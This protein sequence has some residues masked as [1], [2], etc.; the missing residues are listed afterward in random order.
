MGEE[1]PGGPWTF[2]RFIKAAIICAAMIGIL[3]V[4][5]SVFGV[6]IPAWAVTMFWIVLVAGVAL[7]AVTLL[8]RWF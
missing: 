4:A 8:S 2:T 6:T 3:Y 7:I 5:L 1:L